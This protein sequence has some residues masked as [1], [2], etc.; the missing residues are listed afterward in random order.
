MYA[1]LGIATI[2]FVA[3]NCQNYGPI[4]FSQDE[5]RLSEC[6]DHHFGI[7]RYD[8]NTEMRKALINGVARRLSQRTFTREDF[9]SLVSLSIETSKL[10]RTYSVGEQ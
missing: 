9:N 3:I 2:L 10:R 8:E 6:I 7:A 1:C 5:Q 4:H